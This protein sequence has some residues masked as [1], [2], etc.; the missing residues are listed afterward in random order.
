MKKIRVIAIAMALVLSVALTVFAVS[1]FATKTVAQTVASCCNDASCCKDGVCKMNGSC[2]TS[3]ETCPLKKQAAE[4][5]SFAEVPVEDATKQ[6]CHHG[7]NAQ[8]ASTTKD[9]CDGGGSA[10]CKSGNGSCCQ[11]KT[12]AKL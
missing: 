1:K 3:H 11:S 4:K 2:C 7:S 6:S 12:A 9:C 5:I 10:C 8:Q